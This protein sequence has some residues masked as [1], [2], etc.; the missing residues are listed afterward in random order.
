MKM[1]LQQLSDAIEAF[2]KMLG[3]TVG[4]EMDLERKIEKLDEQIEEE[5]LSIDVAAPEEEPQEDTLLEYDKKIMEIEHK[6]SSLELDY[7]RAKGSIELDY[8]RNPPEGDKVTEAT[9]SAFVKCNSKLADIKQ[10]VL[11]AKLE[12]DTFAFERNTKRRETN[13]TRRDARWLARMQGDQTETP[14]ANPKLEKLREKKNVAEVELLATRARIEEIRA[15]ITSYQLLV[16][17]Y[18]SGIIK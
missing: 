10:Q 18:T 6:I 5:E 8:R 13:Q 2:P 12:K 14:T 11:D 3:D 15:S 16:Q 7:E 4:K 1:T 9:V 17:L